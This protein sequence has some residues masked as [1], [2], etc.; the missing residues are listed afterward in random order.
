MTSTP[1]KTGRSRFNSRPIAIAITLYLVCLAQAGAAPPAGQTYFTILMGFSDAYRWEADC[2]K[3][4]A[5]TVC[6]SDSLCG[7]WQATG[8]DTFVL[9]LSWEENGTPIA[10]TG[11]G[12]SETVGKKDS[13]GGVGTLEIGNSSANFG[14]T[15]RPLKKKKCK[16]MLRK[17]IVANPPPQV[18]QFGPCLERAQFGP[19]AISEYILPFRVG[20]TYH[21]S[22]TY[23]YLHSTH[24]NEMAYDFDLPLG[25]Q[26]VAA[27]G[28]EVL[29]VSDHRPNDSPW[30]DANYMKIQHED[31]TVASY[32][33]LAQD[34]VRFAAGATVEQGE[35]IA[36]ASM[37][38]TILPHLHFVVF[39][40]ESNAEGRDVAVNFRNCE[41]PLDKRGSLI[42]DE[43]YK[44]LR[45]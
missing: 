11:E 26:I 15:G 24:K 17:W 13:I 31:G 12:R 28:G 39:Q 6:T 5:G 43:D 22:Q 19:P 8:A 10:V 42:Q 21:L 41:G 9:S 45:Y 18:E 16:K 27:R 30:P 7:P 32:I 2:L 38:G 35:I 37:S 20:R 4:T 44:A 40:D 29:V 25:G 33:H 1:R 36:E 23:C 14:F 3:F 34:S